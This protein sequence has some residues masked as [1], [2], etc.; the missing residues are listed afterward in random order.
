[1]NN[2]LI[3]KINIKFDAIEEDLRKIHE[4][5]EIKT[6]SAICEIQETKEDI[7]AKQKSI[8]DILDAEIEKT[9]DLSLFDSL[10]TRL[11]NT[12]KSVQL[13]K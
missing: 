10:I 4:L 13:I 2:K 1:M 5:A 3:D 6:I 7:I 11:E 9:E 8:L 12:A